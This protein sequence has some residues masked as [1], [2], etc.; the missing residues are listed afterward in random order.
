MTGGEP[1]ASSNPVSP[2]KLPPGSVKTFA[3]PY[4]GGT[5]GIRALGST[6]TAACQSCGSLIDVAN[7][8][9]RL[10]RKAADRIYPSLIP[11]GARGTLFGTEWEVI[12]F[13]LRRDGLISY[14][15]FYTWREYLLFNPYQGFRFLVEAD[16]HWNFVK[17]LHESVADQ[18]D[19]TSSTLFYDGRYYRTYVHD[20]ALVVYVMG[21]FY[22]RVKMGE[23]TRVADFVCPPYILSFERSQQDIIWSHGIYVDHKVIAEA[24]KITN[25]PLPQG[26]APNQPASWA[27]KSSSVRLMTAVFVIALVTLQ[28][29]F[30]SLA[31]SK[32]LYYRAMSVTAADKGHAVIAD[33]IDV[34]DGRGNIEVRAFSPVQNNWVELDISL[35]KDG[36]TESDDVILPVEYYTGFDSDG[37]WSEGGQV[38]SA[39][40]SSVDA[41]RYRLLVE[42]DAGA[43]TG[44]QTAGFDVRL[45]R[46]V[47]IWSNFWVA[48]VSLLLYPLWFG[49]RSWNFERRRWA[50]SDY[51]PAMYRSGDDD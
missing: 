28:L 47:P 25:M 44:G 45:T 22:W 35:V 40:L 27:D 41:G 7:E 3:C 2:A 48:L 14:A 9:C 50:N 10:I 42:P 13:S 20:D 49:L 4:C 31:T 36:S 33:P 5:V 8:N 24:F 29:L 18:Q 37:F 30:A 32:P 39:V 11:M 21:E 19:L 1:P 46:N 34:P 38:N 15:S 23:K 6:V 17:T 26:V 16:N 43:F 12:G 51:A